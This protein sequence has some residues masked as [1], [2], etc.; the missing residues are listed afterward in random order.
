MGTIIISHTKRGAATEVAW[1][2][3]TPLFVQPSPRPPAGW[4][5]RCL[6]V[7]AE[8]ASLL[9]PFFFFFFNVLVSRGAD[10]S[11]RH[12]FDARTTLQWW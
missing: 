10:V 2:L 12:S 5:G 1:F 11:G 4:L 3:H 8:P 9:V 6:T 7:Q